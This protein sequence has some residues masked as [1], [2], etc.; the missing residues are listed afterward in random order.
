MAFATLKEDLIAQLQPYKS[1][2]SGGNNIHVFNDVSIRSSLYKQDNPEIM[3]SDVMGLVVMKNNAKLVFDAVYVIKEAR[4]FKEDILYNHA[5]VC[6]KEVTK[7]TYIV[8]DAQN[9]T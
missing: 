2:I 6:E 9:I 4:M 3:G 5:Y 7:H 1:H 8:C